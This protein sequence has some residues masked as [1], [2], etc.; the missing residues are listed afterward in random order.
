MPQR[1]RLIVFLGIVGLLV[2]AT[3][4]SAGASP[5]EE[6]QSTEAEIA[7]AQE[8]LREL[9]SEESSALAEYNGA[10]HK[11][12]ELNEEIEAAEEDLAAAEEKL[13]QAEE[14]LEESAAQGYKSGNVAL[15]DV[16]L[17]TDNFQEF[18]TRLDLWT[19]MLGEEREEYEAEI[20]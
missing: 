19:R 11:M 20:G 1:V 12:N 6:I 15:M 10:L 16:L 3:A 8:R 5:E 17:G 4:I 13:A 9:R 7:E 14:E 2:L 18:A